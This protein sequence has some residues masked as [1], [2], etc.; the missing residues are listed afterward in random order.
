MKNI[1]YQ[2]VVFAS[3]TSSEKEVEFDKLAVYEKYRFTVMT[4]RRN[5]R[6]Y[7]FTTVVVSM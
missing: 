7:T 6:N 2:F 5:F 3:S 4:T 1:T